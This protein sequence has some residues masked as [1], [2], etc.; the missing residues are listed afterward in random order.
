MVTLKRK[1]ILPPELKERIKQQALEWQEKTALP[2]L[3]IASDWDN[4]LGYC[5]ARGI[6]R[7]KCVFVCTPE[8]FAV[9]HLEAAARV[10]PSP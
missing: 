4:F 2:V 6:L 8:E 3:A 5:F 7:Q 1:E 10:Q 9:L